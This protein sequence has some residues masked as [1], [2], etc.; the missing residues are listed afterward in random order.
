MALVLEDLVQQ[1][2][3]NATEISRAAAREKVSV[4]EDGLTAWFK[5]GLAT[6]EGA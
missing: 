4:L 5:A 3:Q 2:R 6:E 1:A